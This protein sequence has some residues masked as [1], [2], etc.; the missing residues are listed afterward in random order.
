MTLGVL[1]YLTNN[2]V[3]L[4]K[5]S[6]FQ[7]DIEGIFNYSV[8]NFEQNLSIIFLVDLEKHKWCVFKAVH[9]NMAIPEI[10]ITCK[11]K[12]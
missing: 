5:P 9:C 3:I 2:A 6:K 4:I 7:S 11:K 12:N 1:P 10:C 8:A